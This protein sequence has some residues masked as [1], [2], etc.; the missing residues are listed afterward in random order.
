MEAKTKNK[1]ENIIKRLAEISKLDSDVQNELTE[2]KYNLLEKFLKTDYTRE[3][4]KTALDHIVIDTD[5]LY[6]I[7]RIK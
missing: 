5:I 2:T 3:E 1:K 7:S 6:L 4:F